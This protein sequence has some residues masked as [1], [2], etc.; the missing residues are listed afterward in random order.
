MC[1]FV[2]SAMLGRFERLMLGVR[3]GQLFPDPYL[4]SMHL[5]GQRPN[6]SGV[7]DPKLTEM[8]RLQRRTFDPA[9]RRDVVWDIQRYLAEQVYYVYGPSARVVAAWEPYVRNFAPNLGNDYGGRLMAAW[10]DSS[11]R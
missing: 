5:P 8:I 3:W 4:G 9:R 11:A 1:A 6:S 7:N 2:S 10:L